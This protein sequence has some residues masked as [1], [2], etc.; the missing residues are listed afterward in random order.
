MYRENELSEH[1]RR[2]NIKTIV[3]AGKQSYTSYP[4]HAVAPVG[5]LYHGA[6][7]MIHDAGIVY[8]TKS[9]ALEHLIIALVHRPMQ[10]QIGTSNLTEVDL[11]NN[12]FGIQQAIFVQPDFR[13]A[14]I[15][16]GLFELGEWVSV[17]MGANAGLDDIYLAITDHS[18]EL[19]GR[20]SSMAERMAKEHRYQKVSPGAWIKQ[21]AIK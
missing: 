12:I 4:L 10:R 18:L 7:N 19:G 20:Q 8:T 17:Q 3:T 5:I 1:N 6:G 13:G 15:G 14:G 2:H 9:L 21:V 16:A 11:G